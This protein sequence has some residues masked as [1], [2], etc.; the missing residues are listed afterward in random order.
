MS[1]TVA[2]S[3]GFCFGVN[4]AINIVNNL[5]DKNVKVS[6]LGPII[7]N[8][9]VVNELES[10]GCKAV[11]SIDE[12]ENG[13]TLVIRSHGVPKYVIDKLV[14]NGVKYED[15]TCPFVKKIHN[16]VANPDNKD[17]IVLIAGNSV[18]PE[19][20][21]IIGHCS[22][23][24]HTFKNSEEIDEI[25]SNIL[26][27][28]NKQVFV[29][30]QTTFDTKEWKKCV[31]KIKKLCT[32]A[33]IFDTI[34]N[35][36]SVRQ[37][38]ADLLAAQS[39][40]M[41]VI[42]DRH[43]SNTGKLFDICKRQCDNTVLIETAD[44]LNAN[45]VSVAEKIGVTAGASTP[46]R[47]IKEVLDTMSEIKSGVTN[48]EESFEALLEESLKNLNTNERVMGTVLSI[49]PNEVQVD[50]GRKQT[51]FIPAN[52]LSNDP[53]AKP[54][55]IVK[56][57]DE[58]ELLIMKTNDQEGTIMLSK[59]RVDAA[60]GWE[61]LESKV[62][63]QEILTGKV[64]E[65]VKGG[66][67]VIYNDVRVFIPASQA[68]ATREESLE[69]LVGKEVQFRLI[70]VSQR[71]RR[72]RAIGSIRSVLKEQRAAQREEFWKNC[73]I[74]KRYT[75]VV[76]SLTSYGAFVDLGGVFGMIH[77]SELSWTHIKHPSEVVNVGD[78]V[79]VYVKDINEETKKISLGF[80]NADEN[81]WEILKNQYPEGTVVKATIVGL[82][83]FGAFANIIPG[84]D[85]LIHISQIANKRIEKPADVLSVGETVEAKITAIDFDKKRVSLSMRA[86]LPEDEQAPAE[87]AEEVAE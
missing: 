69:D 41:V 81:P 21:G 11:S 72:K 2:K 6:T 54:E 46:A 31:K 65:A 60:K 63:S 64:T 39:D 77:I 57:G 52:E 83:S 78:T 36:T 20:E 5:L 42:G 55:D 35:A 29:V 48:G 47:I 1:I 33:K 85:G 26:K 87:A 58:I 76:K 22:T 66:V 7:H 51:G 62:D 24:C 38:E 50:V 43:S 70:E 53:N 30:A 28:N 17:G 4:R 75:G 49:A 79:E 10:R 86:L 23:E 73:E 3:A 12:V 82:T 61:I 68:T 84:I 32:N 14:E 74:G 18:H 67:I 44:E 25:Y 71:G 15:A 56:V 34:C 80:K 16:I 13:A 45:Q 37:T 59:R 9:E 27:T 8:M 40:F 19:V